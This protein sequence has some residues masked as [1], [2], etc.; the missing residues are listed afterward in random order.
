NIARIFN[1]KL[2]I[3]TS[4]TQN[5][6]LWLKKRENVLQILPYNKGVAKARLFWF[7]STD[8]ERLC[9]QLK[10]HHQLFVPVAV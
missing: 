7:F 10:K 1:K 6:I 8:I 9:F 5:P 2:E 4:S 3:N